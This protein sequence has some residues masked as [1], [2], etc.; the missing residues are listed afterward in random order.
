[1]K[2]RYFGI[3]FDPTMQPGYQ[4]RSLSLDN[5]L[6]PQIKSDF[7]SEL[8]GPKSKGNFRQK[9]GSMQVQELMPSIQIRKK[10][11]L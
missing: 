4:T 5:L 8:P 7:T 10:G 3:T 1:M 9:I 2:Q 6:G 11:L